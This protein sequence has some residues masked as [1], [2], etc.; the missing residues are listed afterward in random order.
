MTQINYGV[1]ISASHS[2]VWGMIADLGYIQNWNP[3]VTK[4]YYNT[5]QVSGVGAGRIC[6]LAP[7]GKIEEVAT[8]WEE[9]KSLTLDIVPVEKVPPFKNC[10]AEITVN[11]L[12]PNKQEVLFEMK[13]EM[14]LGIIG[15][16]MNAMMVKKNFTNGISGLMEGLKVHVEQGTEIENPRIL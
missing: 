2:K 9:G 5:E 7:M 6:E 15:M 10:T 3:G 8:Q 14:G 16:A 13:Y 4:S 11:E 1:I 12:G